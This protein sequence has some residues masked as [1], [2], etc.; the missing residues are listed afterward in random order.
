MEEN[1][2]RPAEW[3][4]GRSDSNG[5]RADGESLDSEVQVS[6]GV[7]SGGRLFETISSRRGSIPSK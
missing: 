1:E 7:K 5:E 2:E 4:E 3:S 6:V